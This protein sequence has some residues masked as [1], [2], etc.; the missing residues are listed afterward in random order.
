MKSLLGILL[1]GLAGSAAALPI[2]VDGNLADW[3][4]SGASWIPAA[5]VHSTVE[6]QTGGGGTRLFPG[7]GGQAY[8]AEAL[9]ATIS[10]NRLYIALVT[11]HNPRTLNK[12]SS[13]SFGAGDFALDF[14]RD[15]SYEVG[16]NIKHA[17][18]YSSATQ[19]YTHESFGAQSNAAVAGNVFSAR[20]GVYGSPTWNLGLWNAAGNYDPAHADPLHPTSLAAGTLLGMADVAYTL[21]GQSGWGNTPGDKHYFY[22]IGLDLSLLDAAGWDGQTAF[23]IHWTELCANDSILVDPPPAPV[24]E[25]GGLALV[26]GALA[27]LVALRRRKGA[28]AR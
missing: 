1:A 16:V 9:Y 28:P 23:N 7:Y 17:L 12:P 21:V 22:E 20:N 27:G 14:G 4:V 18:S 15:G 25:P 6:D 24:S 11:G 8:D 13:N 5:G 3:G 2:T 19:T 26:T 10:G